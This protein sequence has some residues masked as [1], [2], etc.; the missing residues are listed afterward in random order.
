MEIAKEV[1]AARSTSVGVAQ[2]SPCVRTLQVSA[3]MNK[4]SKQIHQIQCLLQ[5]KAIIQQQN[6]L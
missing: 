5:K 2:G 1:A 4:K 6:Q 3:K